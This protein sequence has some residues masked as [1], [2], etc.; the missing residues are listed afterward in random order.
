LGELE[1]TAKALL[2]LIGLERSGVYDGFG[3]GFLDGLGFG[4]ECGAGPVF[5]TTQLTFGD[6]ARLSKRAELISDDSEH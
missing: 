6:R 4:A 3:Q 5:I 2:K 1:V